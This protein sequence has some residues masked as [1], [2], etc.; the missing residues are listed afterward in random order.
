MDSIFVA[1]ILTMKLSGA[2]F[3]EIAKVLTDSGTPT[4]RGGKWSKTTVQE[5]YKR[6]QEKQK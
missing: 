4:K 5:I 3:R 6:E 2:S 1:K